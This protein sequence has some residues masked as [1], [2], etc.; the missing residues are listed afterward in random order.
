MRAT[1]T[2]EPRRDI[3]YQS[4][5]EHNLRGLLYDEL[6]DE[7]PDVHGDHKDS[8]FVFS[9][10]FP[11]EEIITSEKKFILASY[12]QDYL[13]TLLSGIEDSKLDIG[14]M[15]FECSDIHLN[16]IPIGR[17][18]VLETPTGVYC[19]VPSDRNQPTYW[20]QDHGYNT[21]KDQI[22]ASLDWKIDQLHPE[23]NSE[24]RDFPVFESYDLDRTFARP[25]T[26]ETNSE[27]TMVLSRWDLRYQI[28]NDL[29][30]SYIQM[31]LD[32]GIGW[33]NSLGFG[34]VLKQME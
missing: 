29:H 8:P 10:V 26:V 14:E 25:V 24:E 20:R 12:D 33:K 3:E 28:R 17:E 23:Y 16:N 31:A 2:L 18:G 1:V 6:R 22:E 27:L 5:Y 30:R 32:T 15:P 11:P 21:F 13:Y 7:F 9:N 34:F 19:E 4:N